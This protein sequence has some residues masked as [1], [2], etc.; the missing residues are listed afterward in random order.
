MI[1]VNYESYFGKN[2]I[3]GK[4]FRRGTLPSWCLAYSYNIICDPF[5]NW[6]KKTSYLINFIL[7]PNTSFGNN[8]FLS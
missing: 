5:L 7:Q 1:S 4:I 8:K 2:A 6:P 3:L